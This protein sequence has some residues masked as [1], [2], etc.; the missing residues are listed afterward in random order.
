MAR[1]SLLGLGHSSVRM[2]YL[3][4]HNKHSNSKG[5]L[6]AMLHVHCVL[7]RRELCSSQLSGIQLVGAASVLNVAALSEEKKD[8]WNVSHR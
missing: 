3:R 7:G 6:I 4:C 1:R 8:L 5:L 2:G